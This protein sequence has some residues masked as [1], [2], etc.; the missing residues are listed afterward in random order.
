MK[1]YKDF[2]AFDDLIMHWVIT[3]YDIFQFP[4]IS[5]FHGCSS[6]SLSLPCPYLVRIIYSVFDFGYRE[7]RL[8]TNCFL[9]ILSLKRQ[10]KDKY[11]AEKYPKTVCKNMNLPPQH[12]TYLQ[13]KN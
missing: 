5:D 2:T 8:L 12:R 13:D 6:S 9:G 10:T 7:V 11:F 4:F 1:G 3:V